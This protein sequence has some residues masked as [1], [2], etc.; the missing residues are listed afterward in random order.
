M[1]VRCER[2]ETEYEL[3]DSSVSAEGTQVQCTACGHTFT[4]MRPAAAPPPPEPDSPPPAEWL[5]ETSD[6]QAHRFRN[7]TSLQK[8]IIERKVTRDDRISRTGHAWRRLGEIVELAPFFDVVDEAD[9]ARAAALTARVTPPEPQRA[10]QTT[11]ARPPVVQSAPMGSLA[12]VAEARPVVS[13]RVTP[14]GYGSDEI[15]TKSLAVEVEPD[16]AITRVPSGN[17]AFKLILVLGVAGAVAYMGITQFWKKPGLL[18]RRGR[19]PTAAVPAPV[20][21]PPAPPPVAQEPPP[22]PVAKEVPP[23]PKETP[24]KEAT[25]AKETPAE[26]KVAPKAGEALPV[27]YEKIVA[28]ADRLLEN[29]LSQK[30][31]R[32]YEAALKLKPG[33]AEALTGLGY[34]ALD[35]GHT[36]LAFAFFKK[37]LAQEPSLGAAVFGL[38]EAHRAAGDEESALEQYRRYV[39]VDPDGTDVQAA[40]RQIKTIEGHLARGSAPA[41]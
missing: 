6:G 5:L 26:A 2:C 7:L 15:A 16:T 19:A 36:D 8:W 38:A 35:R 12:P 10:R 13:Q 21:T 28:E 25:V 1:D 41:P 39:N 24:P 4:V 40:R 17:S 23:P 22:P 37:A 20:V 14:V 27:S 30:A 33:G 11:Q 29:G 32:L 18:G 31:R 3:E 34:V 9:R